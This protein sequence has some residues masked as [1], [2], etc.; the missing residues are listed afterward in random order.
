[1]AG[2]PQTC[3][4]PD[5]IE[6]FARGEAPPERRAEIEQALERNAGCR[7]L[8]RQLTEGKYPQL[9]NYTIIDQIGKGGFGVVYKAIHH[10]KERAEALKVLFGGARGLATYF[11]NE[12]HLIAKLRH[13]NIATLFDA[14]LTN[15][16]LYYTMEFVAGERLNDHIR[17][18]DVPLARRIAI[19]RTVALAMSYAHEQGVVHRDLKPQNI[20]IDDRGEPHIVDFGIA[21]RLDPAAV[22]ERVPGGPREGPVGTV[23]Y[24]APEQATGKSIDARA[25]VYALG[26]LLFHCVTGEPARFARDPKRVLQ[27]LRERRVTQPDDLAAIIARSVENKPEDRYQTCREFA[28][29]L[30]RFVQGYPVVARGAQSVGY[31]VS[32]GASF[33]LRNHPT[34]VYVA[35]LAFVI[36]G[37]TYLAWMLN[38]EVYSGFDAPGATYLVAYDDK[39]REQM[40]EGVWDDQLPEAVE[41][42]PFNKRRRALFGLVLKRMATVRPKA[43]ALDFFMPDPQP[44]YDPIL[45]DGIRA[46]QERADNQLP[47][48]V[49]VG[50]NEL[51]LNADPKVDPGI[52]AVAHG[53]GL[54][55]GADPSGSEKGLRVAH[56]LQRGVNETVPGLALATYAAGR[57]PDADAEFSLQ[58]FPSPRVQIRFRRHEQR[59]GERRFLETKPIVRLEDVYVA[60]EAVHGPSGLLR[61][62]MAG[63]AS[64]AKLEKGDR[65]GFSKLPIT[66]P[67]DMDA[68]IVSMADVL[69]DEQAVRRLKAAYVVMGE[70]TFDSV[71]RHVLPGGEP[72]YGCEVHLRAID[73][74]VNGAADTDYD[75]ARLM[76]RT[77]LWVGAGWVLVFA[78]SRRSYRRVRLAYAVLSATAIGGV[79]LVS[80]ASLRLVT[81]WQFELALAI[82]A[83]MVSAS[84]VYMVRITRDNQLLM[85]PASSLRSHDDVT[86]PSTI[87]AET[88]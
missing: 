68:R 75:R 24:I 39:T 14:Q 71:D 70:T 11:E 43:V 30:D 48:P 59:E 1:M 19:I 76:W 64:A 83:L 61:L 6:C 63:E 35:V 21:M 18:H 26:A 77:M 44:E 9:P 86:L 49:V 8:F 13:P 2:R 74:L 45:L 38:A 27:L 51:D 7:E 58:E 82:G 62:F 67:A 12:V 87:L 50:A 15:P 23:G 78:S 37:L 69:N 40:I 56:V 85:A 80:Y 66:R 36:V 65:V 34:S 57:Q 33:A 84:L 52:L 60:P 47:T 28:D 32:R 46:L 4:I 88:Q 54:L 31:R 81:Q 53:F 55:V 10:E 73:A 17:S 42:W 72:L 3:P 25:D 29:D 79:L 5:L 41:P 22:V 20:L 16:P